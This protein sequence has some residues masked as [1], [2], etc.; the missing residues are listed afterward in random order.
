[1]FVPGALAWLNESVATALIEIVPFPRAAR[2]AAVK[3]SVCASPVP[4]SDFVME[5]PPCVRVTTT[6]VPASALIVAT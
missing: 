2:S 6:L 5:F 4:T 1:M 3:L